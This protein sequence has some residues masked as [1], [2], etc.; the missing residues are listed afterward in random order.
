MEIFYLSVT[1]LNNVILCLKLYADIVQLGL[2]DQCYLEM[3]I[4]S[5]YHQFYPIDIQNDDLYSTKKIYIYS[6]LNIKCIALG[7]KCQ[8]GGFY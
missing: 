6:V 4:K 1:K 8:Y 3:Y 5:T 7:D 2:F